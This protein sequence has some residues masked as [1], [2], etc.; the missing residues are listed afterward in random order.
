MNR[1]CM[2]TAAAIDH[3]L[4]EPDCIHFCAF[5]N[6]SRPPEEGA[7]H[8]HDSSTGRCHEVVKVTERI[9]TD[10]IRASLV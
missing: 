8:F 10:G 7:T 3:H 6:A 2:M 4:K 9:A 1:R 5:V